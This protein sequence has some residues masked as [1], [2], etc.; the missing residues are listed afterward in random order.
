MPRDRIPQPL[1]PP[2]EGGFTNTMYFIVVDNKQHVGVSQLWEEALI[3]AAQI[4]HELN[5]PELNDG[6]QGD[7]KV[8]ILSFMEM[9]ESDV[10]MVI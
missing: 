1:L 3:S 4:D 10:E 5:S 7:H 6:V 9:M 8:E 2:T